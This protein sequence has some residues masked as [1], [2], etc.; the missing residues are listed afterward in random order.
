MALAIRNA[1]RFVERRAAPVA[2]PRRRALGASSSPRRPT[3]PSSPARQDGSAGRCSTPSPTTAPR[4]PGRDPIRAL[5]RDPDEAGAAGR[6]APGS[7]RRRRRDPAAH[8]R[9]RCSP[10]SRGAVDV[11]HAA[12]VIHPDRIDDFEEINARGTSQRAH[13]R[14]AATACGASSTSRRTARSAPTPTRPTASATTSRTTRTTGYGRSKMRAE[15]HVAAAVDRRPRRGHRPAA[16]VLRAVPAGPA[17]DVLHDGAHGAVPDHRRRQPAALDGVRRQPRPGRDRRRAHADRARAGRGGS[18]TPGRTR[19][20][21]IVE[22]VGAALAAEGYD[23]RAQPAAAAGDRRTS[24]R[25][26]RRR[27]AAPRSVRASG[28]RARRARQDDRLRHLGGDQPSSATA[29]RSSSPRACGAACAG[30]EPQGM[31]I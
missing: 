15:L 5:V 22:T 14:P 31:T 12:G 9:R 7:S 10:G 25:A 17:D 30:A 23:V 1:R 20:T 21:E 26:G 13:R 11:I 24:R 3:P 27:P 6:R 29:P 19:S 8:A 2:E 28:P 18:P 16:V 4:R